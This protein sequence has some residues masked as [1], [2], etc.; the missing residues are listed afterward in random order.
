MRSNDLLTRSLRHY[1][2]TNL[3]VV[4]GVATAVTV[5][6][7]ALLVGD[8]VRGSLR[9]LALQRLGKTDFVIASPDFFTSRLT[10]IQT[11]PDFA[12]RFSEVVPLIALPAMA[13]SQ[14]TGRRAGRVVAYGVDDT[15]WQFNGISPGSPAWR[16]SISDREVLLS[17]PLAREI[18]ATEGSTVL[19]RI[20]RPSD[21]PLESLHG[22]KDDVGRTVR[23]TVHRILSAS[24]L[25]E[26]SLQPQQGDVRAAFMTLTRLQ[27]E[28][29]A[30]AADRVRTSP[31]WVNTL[32]VS[33]RDMGSDASAGSLDALLRRHAQLADVGL[34]VRP[35]DGP[36]EPPTNPGGS[37]PMSPPRLTGL[38]VEANG[39]LIDGPREQTIIETARELKL[40]ATPVLTY[41]VNA[42]RAGDRTTPYSLVTAVELTTL[43]PD[44]VSDD[45]RLPPIVLNEWT[46]RDLMV[47]PGD[48]VTL[49][50]Y[51]W[52]DPGR[53]ITRSSSFE[54][55]AV[56]PMNGPAADRSFSPH[57]PGITDTLNLSDWDPPFPIDLRR[58]RN[59]DEE[60]WDQY[61]TTPKAFVPEAFGRAFWGSRYGQA[62]SVRI[63][64]GPGIENFEQELRSGIDPVGLGIA[65]RDVRGEALTASRGATNFGEYFTYFSLFLVVSALLLTALF[66]KLGVEQR[67]REVGLL[68]AV[69][70]S[71]AAVRRLFAAEG[72]LLAL[73]GSAIGIL[74]ALAYAQLLMTGLRTWWVDA[75]GTT[76]L[77]LHVTPISLAAGVVGGV[78]AAVACIWWT[79]RT[80]SAVSE[81]A[82]LAGDITREHQQLGSGHSESGRRD[83]A[84]VRSRIRNSR[85]LIFTSVSLSLLLLWLGS[86]DLVA[87]SVAFFGAGTLLLTAAL[88]G[89]AYWLGRPPRST[90]SGHGWWALS[91]LGVRNA[92]YRPARSVVSIAVMAAATFILISVG[93]FRRDGAIDWTD[94]QSGTGG[95]PLVVETL[96]PLAVDPND[97]DGRADL[98][99]DLAETVT[100]APFRLLPGDDASCLNLYA[101]Q[102][103]RILGVKREF[104][105]E[106]RF[107]FAAT[108]DGAERDNPWRLL[109]RDEDDGTIPVIGD[110]NSMTYVLH[111]SLGD[112]IVMDRGGRQVRM[113]LVATLTDS[114]FQSELLMS[115]A[116]FLAHFPDQEGY[117]V[118]LVSA[119]AADVA[120]V[121]E[122]IERSLTDHGADAVSTA[123]RLAEFHRVENTY[124]STFQTLGGLGLL[125]GTV[126][127]A[128]VLLRNLLERRRELALLGAVGYGRG[129]LLMIVVSESA[130]LL[131]WGLAAGTVCA[132]VATA[133]AAATHGGRP[134]VAAS[135]WMLLFAVFATGLVSSIVATRAAVASRLLDALRAE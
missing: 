77:R 124:L 92:S 94:R 32:L 7:G 30:A 39:T 117:G 133:P 9:D 41:L 119:T 33:R 76:A 96:L 90:L 70:F 69:G 3:A 98:G 110:A 6:G 29:G 68:R 4:L 109:E 82:L 84:G 43:V 13:T 61:R 131:L 40:S 62:T 134:P 111:K 44:L 54:L 91:R 108:L 99:L 49:D 8:S 87:D 63:A 93:A 52:E 14:E 95:Y 16:H 23:L 19:L 114:I 79:L 48:R 75:V 53:L 66:F 103:P 102:Q 85:F 88:A 130:L 67:V 118:L 106:G 47:K 89:A 59:V 126:G 1:W 28:S 112:E 107:A 25:G 51:V 135:G 38:S 83:H 22:R 45:A 129:G 27:T 97:R 128:A 26:F 116:N 80:L 72:V 65:A 74:G 15:F 122:A 20:Q 100:I 12:S 57:Y 125:L 73:A 5:L 17:E 24:E 11:D 121:S 2:R 113:K 31:S 50:Y 55:A 10:Q 21:I 46:A 36:R 78:L 115:E 60:Y 56:V 101:P 58:I 132:L 123:D 18:G 37:P 42:I 120:A 81:R 104:V 35:L 86:V 71:T 64:A 105:A 127:L 34:A